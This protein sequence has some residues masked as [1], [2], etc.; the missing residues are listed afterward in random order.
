MDVVHFVSDALCCFVFGVCV[1]LP[2]G[3]LCI[4][5]P[6][7]HWKTCFFSEQ[8]QLLKRLTKRVNRNTL[9][10]TFSQ[11]HEQK[12]TTAAMCEHVHYARRCHVLL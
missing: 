6:N 8:E 5:Y 7:V 1:V 10:L 12:Q 2:C 4:E 9:F 3:V 11:D